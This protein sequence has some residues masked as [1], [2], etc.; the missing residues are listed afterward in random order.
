MALIFSYDHRGRQRE[1]RICKEKG[2][3]NLYFLSRMKC[4]VTRSGRFSGTPAPYQAAT[5]RP[6]I[7]RLE[8]PSSSAMRCVF[9]A[10]PGSDEESRVAP[11]VGYP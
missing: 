4:Q 9:F 6:A 3:E 11:V 8:K 2:D 5:Y 1:E 7:I 10:S